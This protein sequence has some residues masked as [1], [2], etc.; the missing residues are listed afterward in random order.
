MNA[1]G[2]QASQVPLYAHRL[3][4]GQAWRTRWLCSPGL[5]PLHPRT[6]MRSRFLDNFVLR[7]AAM[8]TSAVLRDPSRARPRM[9]TD[10]YAG[11]SSYVARVSPPRG[12]AL[13]SRGRACPRVF[14]RNLR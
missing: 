10:A 8:L 4:L 1:K 11:A 12:P 9:R 7:S 14:A 3:G 13:V 6:F 5:A 2:P